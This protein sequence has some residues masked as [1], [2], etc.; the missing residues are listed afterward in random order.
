MSAKSS[1]LQPFN[2]YGSYLYV[3][4]RSGAIRHSAAKSAK[5]C[6]DIPETSNSQRVR[7]SYYTHTMLRARQ[8]PFMGEH[9][10]VHPEHTRAGSAWWL[11]HCSHVDSQ[12]QLNWWWE[13]QW[14]TYTTRVYGERGGDVGRWGCGGAK[15]TST[16]KNNFKF[17]LFRIHIKDHNYFA[18][19]SVLV[20]GYK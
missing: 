9:T 5:Y 12:R 11:R 10:T 17:S 19:V 20:N 13:T 14:E 3:F 16:K 4:P 1:V 15:G 8:N 18:T 2:A 6:P 7:K